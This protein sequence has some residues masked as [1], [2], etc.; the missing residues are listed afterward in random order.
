[1]ADRSAGRAL[2]FRCQPCVQP[3]T[4]RCWVSLFTEALQVQVLPEE[5]TLL[6]QVEIKESGVFIRRDYGGGAYD[7]V[8]PSQAAG[9]GFGLRVP[10]L[11]ISLYV[12]AG[13]IDH[14]I[15][16]FSAMLKFIATRC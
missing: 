5:P 4:Q 16:E 7:H 1:M 12:R 15:Y 10:A 11:I 3:V 8:A 14:H 13:Y 6:R 2:T 9:F